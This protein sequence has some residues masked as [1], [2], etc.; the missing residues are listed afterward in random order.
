MQ[1]LMIQANSD[2]IDEISQSLK[3]KYKQSLHILNSQQIHKNIDKDVEKLS[4]GKLQV[5]SLEETKEYF[6]QKLNLNK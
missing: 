4:H 6:A 5:H 1:T 2:I 3:E